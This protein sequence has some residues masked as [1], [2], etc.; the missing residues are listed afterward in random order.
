[1]RIDAGSTRRLVLISMVLMVLGCGATPEPDPRDAGVDAYPGPGDAGPFQP[2]EL[3]EGELLPG[4]ATTSTAIDASA[5]VQQAA[6]LSVRRRAAFAAGLQFFRLDWVPAPGRPEIDGLGPTFNAISCIACHERNGRGAPRSNAVFSPGVL[7]RLGSEGG[8]PDPNYGD[9]FQPLGIAGVPGEG[10]QRR[11]EIPGPD[12]V[13]ADGFRLPTTAVHYDL[14]ALAFGPL[15]EATRVSPRLTPQLLGQGLLEAIEVGDLEARADPIDADGDGI[16]GRLAMLASG[17]VGRFGW[18]AAAPTV[19]AQ[20][21]GAFFGDMGL[22]SPL[23]PNDHCPGPQERCRE[24]RSGGDPELPSER[25]EATA[26]YVR[27]LGVPRRRNG[28]DPEVLWGKGIFMAIG[29][30]DCHTPSFVTG[31]AEEP[32]LSAARIWPYTDLL[33]HDL[34]DALADGQGEGAASGREWR[35]PPLWGLGLL[36]EVHGEV[37]LLHDGRAGSV[38]EAIA[39]HDGEGRSAREGFRALGAREREALLRFVNSL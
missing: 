39:W 21:A 35:T 17:D 12:F 37:N 4:G 36:G 26:S 33:L 13:F 25:L 24:A 8:E 18:K 30:A 27:L 22:T 20:T 9:Q 1:M 7:L 10:S 19:L 16:S 14:E 6:N 3:E 28:A 31:D 23:H 34:G 15:G 32:E 11:V 5:F 29:C 2:G 38:A